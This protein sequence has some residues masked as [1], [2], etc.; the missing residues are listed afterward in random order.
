MNEE[1][2]NV[3][4]AKKEEAERQGEVAFDDWGSETI[5]E[6]I[7]A[8]IKRPKWSQKNWIRIPS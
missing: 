2:K 8:N 6:L 3:E 4:L 5:G 1:L 7:D